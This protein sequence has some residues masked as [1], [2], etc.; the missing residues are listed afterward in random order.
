MLQ[1]I[2]SD[3]GHVWNSIVHDNITEFA[4]FLKTIDDERIDGMMAIMSFNNLLW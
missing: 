2:S 1:A 3:A 4:G